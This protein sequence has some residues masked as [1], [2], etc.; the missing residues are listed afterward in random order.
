MGISEGGGGGGASGFA[1]GPVNNLFG[2]TAGDALASP[3]TVGAAASKAAAEGVRDTYFTANPDNLAVYN[4]NTRL[5]I[6]IFFVDNGNTTI[7][8]Q[9]RQG[10][11]WVDNGSITGVEGLPGSGT[12]F[13]SIT[14]N[15]LPAIGSGPDFMPF[16]SGL[17]ID[18]STNRFV[19]D[20]GLEVP[21]GTIFIGEGTAISA[22]IRALQGKVVSHKQ[23]GSFFGAAVY[24]CR[25]VFQSIYI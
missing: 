7:F 16:D 13:S 15:H 5:N 8:H 3:S 10:G 21:P 1:L 2:L 4:S 20:K 23:F 25:R 9:V 19:A 17:F 6:R 24:K 12:D 11:S 18:P 14:P 22:S